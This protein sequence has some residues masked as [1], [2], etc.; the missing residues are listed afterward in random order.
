M[1]DFEYSVEICDRDWECFFAECEECNL[2]PP[3]LAGV[4]DSGMSDFDETG[5]IQL[6]KDQKFNLTAGFSEADHSIDTPPD[7]E[8]SPVE[9]YLSKYSVSGIESVLSGSEEDIHLQSVNMFFE[10]LKNVA[11]AEKLAEPN[12]VR[13][14]KITEEIKLEQQHSDGQQFSS[15]YKP[16]SIRKLNFLPARGDTAFGK[17]PTKPVDTINSIN[18]KKKIKPAANVSPESISGNSV[19]KTNKSTYPETYPTLF[20]SEEACREVNALTQQN[21]SHDSVACSETLPHKVVKGETCKPVK[22]AKWENLL[23]SYSPLSGKNSTNSPNNLEIT[24]VKWKEQQIPGISQLDATSI[25]KTASQELSPSASV[26]RKRRKKRR[27]SFEPSENAHGYE[28]Q[29]LA[30]QSD[31][32]EEQYSQKGGLSLHE[33]VKSFP[34]NEAHKNIMPS[35]CSGTSNLPQRISGKEMKANYISRT[36]PPCQHLPENIIRQGIGK[37]TSS[38]ENN[39]TGE[40]SITQL[41]QI[42]DGIMSAA[43]NGD[44]MIKNAESWTRLESGEFTRLNPSPWL[45]ASVSATLNGQSSR[46]SNDCVDMS[47]KDKLSAAKSVLEVKDGN[48]GTENH[49]LCQKETEP[50]QQLEI[51][52]QDTDQYS[53]GVEKTDS[54]NTK[55]QEFKSKACSLLETCAKLTSDCISSSLDERCL[56]KSLPSVDPN[57]AVQGKEDD[58]EVHT[59]SKLDLFSVEKTELTASQLMDSVAPCGEMNPSDSNQGEMKLSVSKDSITYP[60]DIASLS[61]CT[62]D[63]EP[64]RSLSNE[65]TPDLSGSQMSVSPGEKIT[66]ILAKHKSGTKSHSV[67][68]DLIESK[69]D[70]LG[71]KKDAITAS[72]DECVH[73]KAPESNYSVF[74]ISSFWSEMEKLTINDILQLRTSK[75]APPISLPPLPESKESNMDAATDSGFFTQLDESMPV[76]TTEDM[77]SVPDCVETNLPCVEVFDSSARSIMWESEP[78]AVS[79]GTKIYTENMALTPVSHIS[80]PFIPGRSEMSLRKISKNVKLC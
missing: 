48:S 71:V 41:S 54:L 46:E 73:E 77:P 74:A 37:P 23:T 35:L 3:S 5:S 79:H 59:L 70:L 55:P 49:T 33:N 15:I 38:A 52:C 20:I 72:Q 40:R 21:L 43:D 8:G 31:S 62:R 17:E 76:Q 16:K 14:G 61:S 56:S 28:G 78:A 34:L 39:G 63:T 29:V 68:N 25:S 9:D 36:D 53:S 42:D 1:E 75:A 2:L 19:L 66:D 22:D 57:N 65:I 24:N 45:P 4:D 69:Y 67:S 12:Q 26:K 58:L 50:Q 80:H 6:K 27:L 7:C 11:E 51:D 44:K 64:V 47:Q 60:P 10:R 18:T 32:G 13:A 30:Q